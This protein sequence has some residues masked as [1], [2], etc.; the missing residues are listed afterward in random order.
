M[1]GGIT[2]SDE[3]WTTI[4]KFQWKCTSSQTWRQFGWKNV[5]EYFITPSQKHHYD[6]EDVETK[7]SKTDSYL[8]NI[9]L[10]AGKKDS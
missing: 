7:M 3:E 8:M 2:I 10:V 5:I 9:L 6:E 4:W 1:E